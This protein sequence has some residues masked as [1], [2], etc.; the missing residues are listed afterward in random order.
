M[1]LR[2]VDENLKGSKYSTASQFHADIR[3][4]IKNSYIFNKNNEDY[5]KVT[6]EFENYYFKILSDSVPGYKAAKDKTEDTTET[7]HK[8]LKPIKS[9]NKR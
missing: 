9:T 2:T 5:I 7:Q 1:D 4:I 6:L 8:K 3:R